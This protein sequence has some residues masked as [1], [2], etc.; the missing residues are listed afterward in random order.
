MKIC[1]ACRRRFVSPDWSCPFC[2]WKARREAT[3]R[4]VT[5][6]G[7]ADG[8]SPH[9]FDALAAVEDRHFWFSSRNALI[10]WAMSRYFPAARTFLDVGAG[11]GQ[12][13][14]ALQRAFP[15]LRLTACEA[16]LEGLVSAAKNVPTAELVQADI[17]DLPWSE[18]F[19]VAGAF[20]VLEHVTDEAGALQ[21]MVQTL[22]PGGGVIVTVPQHPWLW[23]PVDDYSG[24]VRRYT[25]AL[26]R[27][28]LESAGLR[29]ERMTSFVSLLLP[30]L[31]VSRVSSRGS[32]VDPDTE[33]RMS[34]LVNAA[35]AT[36]MSVERWLIRS[37]VSLP[38]GGS[39]LAV[40]RR[41]DA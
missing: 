36:A 5:G 39:L 27:S 29:V 19:D 13:A 6:S 9:S 3:I 10:A 23:S 38:A 14:R 18:E 32:P 17:G 24:H 40:A 35:G 11:N 28:R 2:E 31:V 8:W 33:Y 30:V 7:T 16:Y 15:A 37:G 22:R 4:C 25:R 41:S 26:L 20:D 12:V 34:T 1:P 21:Q